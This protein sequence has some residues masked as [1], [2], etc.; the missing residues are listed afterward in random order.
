VTDAVLAVLYAVVLAAGWASQHA[1]G[2]PAGQ[3][4]HRRPWATLSA[5]LI[6]GVVTTV[7]LVAA[8]GLLAT[9]GRAPDEL[10]RGQLWRLVTSLT[11]QDGGWS[12]AVFNLVALA[13]V[14]V[15]AEAFWGAG[16]WCVI[17]LTTGIAAQLWGLVV[18]PS[19][20]GNSVAT[21]GLAASLA[22]VA[23]VHGSG[24][25]RVA[26]L[27]SLLGGLALLVARDI[28]GGAV[29]VGAALALWLISRRARPPSRDR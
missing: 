22:T 2:A 21:F 1:P 5:L 3:P 29:V 17:W 28:H 4:G 11:V 8:P 26:G 7:Q 9:L 24:A 12:G 19:G 20:G 16:R 6:V 10:T 14:G 15:T 23:A 18:Q 27:V 13:V 25:A